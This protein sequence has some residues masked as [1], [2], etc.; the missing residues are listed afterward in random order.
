MGVT[1]AITAKQ[2]GCEVFW[3]SEG[4][5]EP[6]RQRA[7]AAGLRDAG[8]LAELCRQ[9]PAIVS[10]CPPEF[11]E[12]VFDAV[13]QTGWRGLYIDAN[14]IA[15][16]RKKHMAA[17]LDSFVDGGIIGMPP[18]KSGES[19]LILSGRDAG[20]AASYFHAG[21]LEPDVIGAEVGQ[22]SALKICFAAYNKG[23]I[24]LF[25]TTLAAA[26]HYGVAEQLLRNWERRG[27]PR[28]IFE[29]EIQRSAP[30][31]WRFVPEMHEIAATLAEAGLPTEFHAAAA[32]VYTRLA[33]FK[34]AD[35]PS[36]ADILAALSH[37]EG[38]RG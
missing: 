24:A 3:C 28:S 12:A 27:R 31:A 21:P 5:R 4:R 7:E 8:T 23:A 30:K 26:E 17:R 10:V 34:D 2:S 15:P 9:C 20:E 38:V 19:W 35:R 25:A 16:Q 6:S 36:M 32:E 33:G 29:G 18:K 11:A 1:A 13:L 37:H 22:A 14:A